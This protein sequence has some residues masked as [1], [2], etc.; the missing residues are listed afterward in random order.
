MI[1]LFF[2]LGVY[3]SVAKPIQKYSLVLG[4]TT[5]FSF[6]IFGVYNFFI[7]YFNWKLELYVW[8]ILFG[9]TFFIM[10][11]FLY[12]L[13]SEDVYNELIES[14]EKITNKQNYFYQF[15]L[16]FIL[17]LAL[18]IFFAGMILGSELK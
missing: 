7:N 1:H 9:L 16:V 17:L 14:R 8:G 3:A 18:T 12:Y 13:L 5:I 6:I 4:V 2:R 11:K 15:V 10:Y